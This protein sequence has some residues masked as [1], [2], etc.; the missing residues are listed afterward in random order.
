MKKEMV[1][2]IVETQN[3]RI[4][5]SHGDD[6]P[7]ESICVTVDQVDTL[8]EWLQEAKAELEQAAD[9]LEV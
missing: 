8:I 4:F 1:P 2:S 9:P 7:H 5:V 3:G 6:G